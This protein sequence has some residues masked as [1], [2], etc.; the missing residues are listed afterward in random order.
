MGKKQLSVLRFGM[1]EA[2]IGGEIK[3]PNQWAPPSAHARIHAGGWAMF[4]ERDPTAR[5]PCS[6]LLLA[7]QLGKC[8]KCQALGLG[9]L[10]H[11]P[12]AKGGHR[13][14]NSALAEPRAG[15]DVAL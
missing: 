15:K 6:T 8:Y 2:C 14:G 13:A 11:F 3:A 9:D 12:K 7:C 10:Y 5:R 1:G 4:K